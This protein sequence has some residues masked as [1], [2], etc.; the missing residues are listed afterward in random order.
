MTI[1]QATGH[2][3]LSPDLARVEEWRQAEAQGV[4]LRRL[5]T[6]SGVS[7]IAPVRLFTV[8]EPRNRYSQP[9]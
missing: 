5:T 9:L 7:Q 8:H 1:D 6:F 2:F 3:Q 4:L